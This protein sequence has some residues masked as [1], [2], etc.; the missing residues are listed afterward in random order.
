MLTYIINFIIL[1]LFVC[2]LSF[3]ARL[4]SFILRVFL[5]HSC[6]LSILL[7]FHLFLFPLPLL[8]SGLH[9]YTCYCTKQTHLHN[10]QQTPPPTIYSCIFGFRYRNIFV[11]CLLTLS[12]YR[13]HNVCPWPM[14]EYDCGAMV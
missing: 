13:L 9:P 7:Q 11:V 1:C 3:S 8:A 4:L 14:N 2:F 10:L 5:A 6:F 12:V